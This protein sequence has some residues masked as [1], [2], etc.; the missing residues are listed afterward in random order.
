[1]LEFCENDE[2]EQMI[3]DTKSLLGI[4]ENIGK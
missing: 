4:L 1:M 3:K 2:P